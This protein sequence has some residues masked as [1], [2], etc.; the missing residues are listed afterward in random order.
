[1]G[2]DDPQAMMDIAKKDI[3]LHTL[4]ENGGSCTFQARATSLKFDSL[5]R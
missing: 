1:M 5:K 3:I 4:N 2:D